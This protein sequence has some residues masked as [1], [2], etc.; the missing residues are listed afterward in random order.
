MRGGV[1]FE[2]DRVVHPLVSPQAG[3]RDHAVIDLAQVGEVLPAHMGRVI[4]ILAVAIFESGEYP[5]S[6]GG[7]EGIGEQQLQAACLYGPF[8]PVRFREEPLQSLGVSML[9]AHDRL[10]VGQTRQRLMSLGRQ[11]YAFQ[12]APH[13]AASCCA[14]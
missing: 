8:G 3:H 2:I 7:G 11:Q 9:G 1:R 6:R 13:S 10:G 12:I 14:D 4:P 5:F